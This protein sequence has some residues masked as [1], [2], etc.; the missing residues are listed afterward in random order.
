MTQ[1]ELKFIFMDIRLFLASFVEKNYLLSILYM[2]TGTIQYI[3]NLYH[4][5]YWY[6]RKGEFGEQAK[7]DKMLCTRGGINMQ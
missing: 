5:K 7:K 3:I 1:F 4:K 2:L 6:R